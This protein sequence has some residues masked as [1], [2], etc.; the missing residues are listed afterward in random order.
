MDPL[1]ATV[2]R[3]EGVPLICAQEDGSWVLELVDEGVAVV[4]SAEQARRV[5]DDFLSQL[6]G[7]PSDDVDELP[8]ADEDT[9]HWLLSLPLDERLRL[10]A[11][12]NEIADRREG[13][14]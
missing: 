9:Q 14:G 12:W 13:A 10:E 3:P 8:R 1:P 6:L 4:L 11:K 2:I 7:G 5:V